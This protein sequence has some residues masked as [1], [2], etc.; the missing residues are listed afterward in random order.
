M[1]GIATILGEPYFETVKSIWRQ[2]EETCRFQCVK[3][4]SIPHFS[5]HVADT[6][7]EQPLSHI[8]EA[9]CASARPFWVRTAGLGIFTAEKCVLYISIVSDSHLIQFHT[10]LWECLEGIGSKP[11]PYYA[12]GQWVPHITL[13]LE[14]LEAEELSCVVKNLACRSFIWEIL[15]DHLA[16]IGE[17]GLESGTDLLRFPF[18]GM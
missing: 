7:P 11:S 16:V 13:A 8:L 10:R 15:V 5:W 9:V 12:P 6:Y 3:A 17:T 18:G 2:V 4:T 1:E 14:G